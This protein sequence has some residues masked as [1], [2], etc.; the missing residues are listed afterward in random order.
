MKNKGITV[1]VCLLLLVGGFG[2]SF[3]AV[4]GKHFDL[5]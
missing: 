5:K 2:S 1:A 4:A 3:A